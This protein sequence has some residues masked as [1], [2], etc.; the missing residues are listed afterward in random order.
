M[1][2]NHSTFDSLHS[3]CALIAE[4][5]VPPIIIPLLSA[6]RLIA[7]PKANGDVRP[8]AIGE[9]L[10]RITTRTICL[11]ER[12]S[13]SEYFSPIQHG[14]AT[15]GG[16]EL[17]TQLIQLLMDQ[18]PEWSVLKT[19]VS[20]AFN[21]ISRK[22]LMEE[23][24]NCFPG[25]VAHVHQMYSKPSSLIYTKNQGD[26][27]GPALFATAIHPNFLLLQQQ[28]LNV[29]ILAYL[30]DIYVV[31]QIA[32]FIFS[33]DALISDKADIHQFDGCRK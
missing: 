8:I 14:V 3:V 17:L 4:G 19:D 32:R 1:Q 12:S 27:L 13:F 2:D 22:C 7:L 33:N 29:T 24:S 30:D 28:H 10:R 15:A 20:N 16:G 6:S 21:P 18:N 11:Q 9:T 25:I 5:N 23:I 26:P 31:L